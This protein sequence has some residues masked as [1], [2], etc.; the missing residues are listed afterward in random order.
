MTGFQDKIQL[1]WNIAELLRGDYK[2]SEYGKVII[3]FTVLKRIDS[4]LAPTKA[5]VLAKAEKAKKDK[6]LAD[7]VFN[8]IAGHSF[9]NKS[10]Y[11]FNSLKA[12]PNHLA[13]N[14]KNY[15]NGFSGNVRA[16]FSDSFEFTTQIEKLDDANLL[17]Q[18]FSEFSKPDLDL[19]PDRVS[20]LEMGYIFEELI[21][22]FSEQSNETAGEHFTPREVIRLMVNILFNDD[23]KALTK[24]GV[25]RSLYDPACGTGGMLSVAEEYFRELNHGAQLE[26]FGQELNPESYGICLSDMLLTG[27]SSDHIAFGNSFTNDGHTAKHFDYML[28]NPPFGVEWKKYEKAIR[29]EHA[30]LG[31]DGRFGAGLPRVSDGSL[32]FL[33]HMI[34]KMKHTE[35]GS[36]LA[37]VFNASP[38]FTGGAGS[39]ESNIRKWIIENDW[40]EAVIALP[41]QL[42]YNTGIFTYIWVLSTRKAKERKG[43]I[44]LINATGFVEKMPKSLGNKRNRIS[45]SQIGEITRIY[46]DFR[47]GEF[48]KIVDNDDFGYRRVTVER[49]LRMKFQITPERVKALKD[50]GNCAYITLEKLVSS[51]VYNDRNEFMAMLKAAFKK[52][53]PACSKTVLRQLIYALGEQDESAPPVLDEDGKP[54]ADSSLRD[55]E[56][57]PK[58]E[59]VKTYFEREVKPFVP[60]AWVD[61]ESEV[62]GYEIPFTRHFYK[63]K[64]LRPLAEIDSDIAKVEAEIL[65][66]L[67]KDA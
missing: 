29:D 19:H 11:D 27:H 40:L 52:E 54:E 42:F 58:K 47:A 22:R 56:S 7:I 4:V 18:V 67:K 32:L 30:K 20:N 17:F 8:R 43:K 26:V 53:G 28:S 25:I 38:M 65:D 50:R 36:R 12:D 13:S 64:P 1:I 61:W 21:R 55:Y 9:H 37:I 66:L 23:T 45:E 6:P 57:V 10:R 2:Q 5:K 44:Q 63:Y 16:I 46:G 35:G 39:G 60:D 34:S 48:C 49:P 24:G 15:I 51:K 62:I 33:Q 31:H 41:D 14:L 3:P 59:S